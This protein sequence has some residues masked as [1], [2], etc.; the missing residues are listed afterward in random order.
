MLDFM[1]IPPIQK[2]GK[3]KEFF[4]FTADISFIDG[5]VFSGHLVFLNQED[6]PGTLLIQ[7]LVNNNG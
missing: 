3:A 1:R 7:W 5:F 4:T 6:C 2:I